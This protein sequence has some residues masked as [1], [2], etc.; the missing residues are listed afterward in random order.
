MSIMAQMKTGR[1][2]FANSTGVKNIV[3]FFIYVAVYSWGIFDHHY[4]ES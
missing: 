2:F 4:G 1:N 3:K